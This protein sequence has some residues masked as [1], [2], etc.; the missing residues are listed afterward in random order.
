[1]PTLIVKGPDGHERAIA[2]VKRVVTVGRDAENDVSVADPS[3]PPT[4]LHLRQEGSA[5]IAESHRDAELIVNG[6]RRPS[7]PLAA[8]DVLR[9]GATE[10]RFETAA[11]AMPPPR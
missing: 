9:A 1:M 6:R 11:P 3:L 2:L 4:A 8:G 7:A 5:W 10:L